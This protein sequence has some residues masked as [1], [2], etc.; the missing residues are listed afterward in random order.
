MIA[1]RW[2]KVIRDIWDNKSRTILVVLSIAI[3]VFAFG[4]LFIARVIG[5]IAL[6]GQYQQTNSPN[7]VMSLPPFDEHFVRWMARQPRVSGAQGRA[8]YN[9]KLVEPGK[10][11]NLTLIA[12]DDFNA[13]QIGRIR[14]QEGQW[15]PGRDE[16]L[17]E[18]STVALT[19]LT[20]GSP[21]VIETTDGRRFTLNFTGTVHDL[22]AIPGTIQSQVT[23]YV[24]FRTLRRLELPAMFNQIE[25]TLDP[26]YLASSGT[27]VIDAASAV[28]NTLQ[29]ELQRNGIRAGAISVREA[30]KHWASD[31]M[32]GLAAILIIVGLGSLLLSGFLV[33]N[34]IS[35]LLAQ[36]RRQ[37]GIMKVIG[38]SR[39]QIVT[40]YLVMVVFLGLVSLVIAIP[41]SLALAHFLLYSVVANFLNFD[42][43]DFYMPIGVLALQIGVAILSPILSALVPVLSGTR[44]TAAEAI[45]DYAAQRGTGL[46]DLLLAQIRGL[47]RPVLISVRNT[48]RRKLRLLM[49]L[50]TLTAA[51]AL[52]MSIM[53][54][55][56]ALVTDVNDRLRMSDFDVQVFLNGVYD[57]P[58]LERRLAQIPGVSAVEGWTRAG[59]QRIR[60]DGS[61]S[62]TFTFYGL[63]Y[64]S[65]FIDP[66]LQ[67]GR[68]LQPENRFEKEIVVT[69]DWLEDEPGVQLGDLI[70][71]ELN[72]QKE[73]WRV[74]GIL[75]SSTSALYGH[76]NDVARF[77]KIPEKTSL[78]LVRT[79]VRDAE[80]QLRVA[81]DVLEFLDLRKIGVVRSTTRAELIADTFG[82]FDILISVLISMAIIVAAVGGLG[83]AGTMSLNVLERT[84]EI[85]VMRAV[86]ASTGAVRRMFIIEGV[87]IGILSAIIALPFSIPGSIGF[88]NILGEVL[89]NRPLP[90]TPTIEG[91]V[92]WFVIIIGISMA[93]S[94]MPAQRASQ[95]SV[96]EALAYE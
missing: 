75:I 34:T 59:V 56:T 19:S 60:A 1:P 8:T 57:R 94:L 5:E 14:P 53:N 27:T 9:L 96:R 72:D 82:G 3:G 92:S 52:F 24:S 48:F 6:N 77:M 13:I 63:A 32:E 39:P 37:I 36:Q 64:N 4:G 73:D 89:A 87:L 51:G 55:R 31:V 83:L 21:A 84:R 58:G 90:Y 68:W 20:P 79:V 28:A 76:F 69:T 18:R 16:I 33:V 49:T 41:A 93:A 10:V 46:V 65:L 7:I 78:V 86:G 12:Y 2:W 80:V 25:L 30:D 71:L 95:I 35:G 61:K 29:R 22:N 23:G 45:S 11:H 42:I 26:E 70:T 44:M 40:V 17:L 74:V 50:L 38:A 91:P 67:S 85:G 15:P 88:G 54:V 47:S 66:L 43:I 81:D 62:A